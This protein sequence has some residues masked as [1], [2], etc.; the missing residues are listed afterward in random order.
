[1]RKIADAITEIVRENDLL[2]FGLSEGL[3]NLSQTARFLQ[4]LVAARTKKDVQVSAITMALSRLGKRQKRTHRTEHFEIESL[5]VQGDLVALTFEKT[6]QVHRQASTL[7]TRLQKADA[8]ITLTQGR[9]E[10]TIIL[11]RR[12]EPDARAI[13]GGQIV[14]RAK[15]V[16]AISVKFNRRYVDQPG[17]LFALLQSVAVQNLNIVEIA[18]SATEFILY[19]DASDTELAFETLYRRFVRH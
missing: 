1:M 5:N 13:T 15:H 18:S 2:Q 12:F 6:A 16:A 8:Y 10:I 4:P 11:D 17:F 9:T 14:Y 7:Y 19:M 3:L